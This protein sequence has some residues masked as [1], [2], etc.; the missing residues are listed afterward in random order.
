VDLQSMGVAAPQLAPWHH[1][2]AG[3]MGPLF[4]ASTVG[5]LVG[6]VVGGWLSDRIGRKGVLIAAVV[7]FGL[8]SLT[9]PLAWDDGSLLAS[10]FLTGCGLGAGLPMVIALVAEAS[11]PEKKVSYVTL[12]YAGTPLGGMLAAYIARM[13][14]VGLDWRAIFYFGGVAPLL[15]APV[16]WLLLPESEAFRGLKAKAPAAGA[17]VAGGAEPGQPTGVARALFGHGRAATTVLLWTSFLCTLLCLYLLLNW[18]P[19]LMVS[20]GFSAATASQAQIWFNVGGVLGTLALSAL[21]AT[22]RVGPVLVAAYVGMAASLVGL[23]GAG[24]SPTATH[25]AAFFVGI[26]TNGAPFILYGLAPVFY[27]A[28]VRGTGVGAAVSFG[29]VGAI[30]GPLLAGALVGAGR[31]PAAV[32]TGILPIVVLAFV[33]GVLLLRRPPPAEVEPEAQRAAA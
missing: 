11:P 22:G 19:S 17:P 16:I 9:T 14:A 28:A 8:F 5:L 25:L 3:Q 20:R 2:Q 33:S 15:L 32:L 27:P 21:L 18:L 1:L 4:S 30:V 12:I 29:R 24:A 31:S 10:R 26:F 13:D 23:A 6:A 7:Q